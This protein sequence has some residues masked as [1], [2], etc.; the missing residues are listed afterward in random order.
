MKTAVRL[1]FNHFYAGSVDEACRIAREIN[2]LKMG[3]N[4]TEIHVYEC[5]QLPLV[6]E[7]FAWFDSDVAANCVEPSALIGA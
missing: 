4:V 6:W 1:E 3:K 2:G 7:C 5:P